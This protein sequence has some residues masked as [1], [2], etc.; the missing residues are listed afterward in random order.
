MRKLTHLLNTFKQPLSTRKDYTGYTTHLNTT[1]LMIDS[2][3][4][5]F[6]IWSVLPEILPHRILEKSVSLDLGF[7]RFLSS[8]VDEMEALSNLFYYLNSY[9]QLSFDCF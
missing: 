9:N 4:I 1:L 5:G 6:D 3:A 7:Y 2:T 8:K